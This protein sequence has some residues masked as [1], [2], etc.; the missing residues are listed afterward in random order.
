MSAHPSYYLRVIRLR[1]K[2][3]A[4]FALVGALLAG[5]FTLLTQRDTDEVQITY[6]V[7]NHKL[8]L[9]E[10]AVAAGFFPNLMQTSLQV[11]ARDIPEAVAETLDGDPDELAARVRTVTNTEVNLIEISAASTD[12]DEAVAI[13]DEFARQLVLFMSEREL[14]TYEASLLE[15]SAEIERSTTELTKIDAEIADLD[16]RRFEL[17]D[18]LDDALT[19]AREAEATETE[20]PDDVR[21]VAEVTAELNDVNDDLQRLE[22]Q[23]TSRIALLEESLARLDELEREGAPPPVFDT[24]DVVPPFPVSESEYRARLSQGKR[25]E[26]NFSAR[27]VPA[28]S[29][30]GLALGKTVSNPVVRVGLG[31][32]AGLT[33]GIGAVLLHL[34]FDPRLRTKADVEEAFDLPVL[35]EIPKFAKRDKKTVELHSIT[36][37]RSTVTEAYRMVRSALIFAK[38]TVETPLTI[39][40][41]GGLSVTNEGSG[42]ASDSTASAP[43]P[44]GRVAETLTQGLAD[45]PG[46]MRVVMVTSPGPSEGKTTTTANLAVVLAEAGYEVLVVNCDYRLPKLHRF[47]GLP[48][49]ARRTLP[50]DVPGVTVVADVSEPGDVNPTTVVE[51]QRALIR[52][53]RKRFDVVLLD[54]APLLAT[55]DAVALLPVVDLVLLVAA[56]GKTDREAATETVDVLRRRRS[57]LAGVV[58]TG[59]TGFGRSRYYY[60]YRYGNYYDKQAERPDVDLAETPP[61]SKRAKAKRRSSDTAPTPR[62]AASGGPATTEPSD[63]Q[64]AVDPDAMVVASRT[65]RAQAS[66]N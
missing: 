41:T 17:T 55:N 65:A 47:F 37:T 64:P 45:S 12:P 59:A 50:T 7:A 4:A 51:A 49:Q 30:G 29:G 58:L 54:T 6:Y 8:V 56:E 5:A 20:V 53:A 11:T 61:R 14:D 31:L 10:D 63:A 52:K 16:V 34:R 57:N 35:A 44:A 26:N 66:R 18:E 3:L 48:H 2:V 21:S 1:W 28:T 13:S 9:S 36:R 27:T 46:E 42:L 43:V 23:R 40:A 38:A 15:A 19:A 24:L 60:Q 32:I 39:D 22:A 25:G 33:L 62:R